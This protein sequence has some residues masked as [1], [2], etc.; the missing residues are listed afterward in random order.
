MVLTEFKEF[1]QQNLKSLYISNYA[2]IN[3]LN[4]DFYSGFSTI[5]GETGAGKSIIM[6]AL[7]LILGQRA[8]LKSL[9]TDTDK[10]IIEAEF[11]LSS[12]SKLTTFF[13][14]NDIDFT[15]NDCIIRR[16]L[17]AA[18]KSRAFINDTPVA[19]NTL[20][21]LTTQL[22]D[23]HS[24][25]DNLLLYNPNYQ[26][27]VVDAIACNSVLLDSYTEK[28]N[29]WIN[30]KSEL[31]KLEENA[32]KMA[33]DQDY[34]NFQYNQLSEA[35]LQ[36][37]E[38]ELLEKEQEMLLHA[39]DIKTGLLQTQVLLDNDNAVLP[40]LKEVIHVVSHTK[41]YLTDATEWLE[42]LN[43]CYVELKDLNSEMT[44][45][46]DN[47]EDNPERLQFVNNRLSEIYTLLKKY[48]VSDVAQ[49]IELRDAL[50]LQLQQIDSSDED[51]ALL[52]EKIE[53]AYSE[54]S[55]QADLVTVSR[56]NVLSNIE[57]Y[58]IKRLSELGMP[59]I[60]FKI[61]LQSSADF[62]LKGRDEV[63]FLFSANKN[64][65]MQPVQLIASGGEISRLMLSL[66][67]LI[68]NK[69]EL[70]T[71]IFDEVD[72]GVSGEIAHRMGDIMAEMGEV[73]QVLTITH[74]PQIAA[75]SNTQYRVYKDESGEQSQT[76]I[77]LL[78]QEQRVTEIAQ[79]LSGKN[80][81]EI[82]VQNARELLAK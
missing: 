68:A 77:E 13:T 66:K 81:S 24:Q 52:N 1:Q 57:N 80:Y 23:I 78:S 18:G 4:I 40:L 51:I 15:Q 61:Q 56:S 6:G 17:T 33:S 21:E 27:D 20:R 10:C 67:A 82:A 45:Y 64:R 54:M 49:L 79:M 39:E 8:D 50:E 55:L 26:L 19:L 48:K 41:N 35:N 63:Q 30:L 11:D 76:F 42:R 9:K 22:I 44:K 25:H 32:R 65:D 16:E 7:S 2:L 36:T 47:V 60:Q 29:Y 5:T 75:R 37:D 46:A 28:Y 12:Y 71:I 38:Q 3:E 72:T 31:K 43:T 74:L 62:G 58:L 34:L 14:D 73:M 70:P 69:A 53:L 59:N